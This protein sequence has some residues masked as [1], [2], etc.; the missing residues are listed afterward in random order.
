MNE[1]DDRRS[2]AEELLDEWLEHSQGSSDADHSRLIEAHPEL[3]AEFEELLKELELAD[4]LLYRLRGSSTDKP[5]SLGDFKLVRKIGEGGMGQVYEARQGS[6]RRTVALKLLSP[7]LALSDSAVRNFKREATTVAGLT[8]PGIVPVHAVGDEDGTHYFAME[9]VNGVS[10]DR[11]LND[12]RGRDPS[13]LSA[14]D[15]AAALDPGVESSSEWLPAGSRAWV[16][17]AAELTADVADALH[18][19]HESGVLHR[20]VKP[21]NILL[22]RDGRPLLTDFGLSL[23]DGAPE[24]TRTGEFKGSPYYVSPEQAMSG[25][26]PVDRRSDV[27]S[28]GVTLF[29]MLTLRR[30]FEGKNALE[31]FSKITHK[32]PPDPER[33]NAA[34]PTDLARITLKAM[35]RDPAR[36]YA[37]AAEFAEDLRRFLDHRPVSARALPKHIAIARWVRREPFRAALASVLLIAL[38]VTGNLYLGLRRTNKELQVSSVRLEDLA[39][40]HESQVD[41]ID[42]EAMGREMMSLLRR[43]LEVNL[44]SRGLEEER[45]QELLDQLD[46]L[47][48]FLYPT[49]MARELIGTE[50]LARTSLAIS[51]QFPAEPDV[52]GELRLALARRYLD[53]SLDESALI[54]ADRALE[55]WSE[56]RSG[57]DPEQITAERL[58]IEALA[59]LSRYEEAQE[60]ITRVIPLALDETV[61]ARVRCY[62]LISAAGVS[63]ELNL[64]DDADEYLNSAEQVLVAT[65]IPACNFEILC[66]RAELALTREDFQL[67]NELALEA[68]ESGE[69]VL[70]KNSSQVLGM[71][72]TVGNTLS[73][74]DRLDEAVALYDDLLARLRVNLGPTHGQTLAALSNLGTALTYQGDLARAIPV[75]EDALKVNQK[76][77]GPLHLETLTCLKDLG[78]ALDVAGRPREALPLLEEA[79]DGLR[80]VVPQPHGRTIIALGSLAATHYSLGELDRAEEGWLEALE[81]SREV[82]GDDSPTTTTQLSNLAVLYHR[83]GRLK[84]AEPLSLEV[85]ETGKRTRPDD[86][87]SNILRQVNYGAL[88]RDLGRNADAE[89]LLADA[90]EKGRRKLPPGHWILGGTLSELGRTRFMGGDFAGSVQDLEE[91]HTL[92]KTFFDGEH[93]RVKEAEQGLSIVY[94][95][96]NEKE[97]DPKWAEL[98][99]TWR[100]RYEGGAVDE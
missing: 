65:N 19:A 82:F 73:A 67:A 52:E 96:W 30:P 39:A 48:S 94:S 2:R 10:L 63:I 85:L 50:V 75:L 25:R 37:T 32:A 51:E 83:L 99:E 16:R 61:E 44:E 46:E 12:L 62:L 7:G 38:V 36:R 64:F 97:P 56:T 14:D 92:L 58:V 90:L 88:L 72:N 70:G 1:Q 41:A 78:D 66:S 80:R 13:R 40:F 11:V 59:G 28:L 68:V 47:R 69:A 86:H 55:L 74:L 43:S 91:A 49:A 76:V 22:G 95:T 81:G 6:L 5:R 79:V 77:R 4:G 26:V 24:V 34:L 53:L 18:F 8:H 29:E 27:Y 71:L 60:R 84:D 35:D 21:G 98:A 45:S 93:P 23:V 3:T 87:Q 20:D 31:V 100:R 54:E 42:A 9:L 33:Y 57:K 89:E 15:L 17:L